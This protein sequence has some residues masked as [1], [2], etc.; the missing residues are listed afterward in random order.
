[1]IDLFVFNR[2]I[3]LKM[4]FFGGHNIFFFIQQTKKY[5]KVNIYINV[6][7]IQIPPPPPKKNRIN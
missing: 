6:I 3:L 4:T 1:M 2:Q 5:V 7:Y